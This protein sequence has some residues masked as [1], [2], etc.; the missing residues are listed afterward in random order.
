MLVLEIY[1]SGALPELTTIVDQI[2]INTGLKL[3]YDNIKML[4]ISDVLG[5][6]HNIAL[7]EEEGNLYCV[8]PLNE[9]RGKTMYL[10]EATIYALLQLG[11]NHDYP[12][13]E[14]AGLPWQ[15]AQFLDLEL[16]PRPDLPSLN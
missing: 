10:T 1:F 9:Y 16:P 3:R 4:L 13:A 8:M 11:G 7:Y 2:R 5:N 14:W 6:E 12:L 15:D